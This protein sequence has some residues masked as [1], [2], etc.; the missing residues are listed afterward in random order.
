MTTTERICL[1]N[2]YRDLLEECGITPIEQCA[3]S[4]EDATVKAYGKALNIATAYVSN[5]N[6]WSAVCPKTIE[7][8]EEFGVLVEDPDGPDITCAFVTRDGFGFRWLRVID[9]ALGDGVVLVGSV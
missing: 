6:K 7:T 8:L 2:L 9:S 5:Q 1:E 4:D 3:C